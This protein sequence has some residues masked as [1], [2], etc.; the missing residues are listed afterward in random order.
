[1]DIEE[2]KRVLQSFADEPAD[3]DI[4]RGKV[5]AQ[6][7][8]DIIDI[9]L[10]FAK[11]PEQQLLVT[12]NEQ[13]SPARIWLL[14]RVA[15]LPQLADR[16]LASNRSTNDPTASS[17]FVV[18][19]GTLSPD[20]SAAEETFKDT[21]VPNAV[22][23][24]LDTASQPI[25]GAT[26]VLYVTSDAGE[27]K[28]TIINR[29]AQIQAQ[30]FKEKKAS[31]LIVP[32]PLGGRAFLTFDDAVIAALV[33]RF[34]FNYFYFDAFLELVRMGAI[35]P[36]FDGYEEMLVEGSKN[37]AVSAL[38]SLIQSLGSSGTIFIAA[39]KAFFEYLSFRTQAKLLD[40]IGDRSAAFSRLGICRWTREQFCEYGR[41][42]KAESPE[43]MY[44]AV[45]ARLGTGH[46]I[47]TRAVLVRRLFDVAS[48][49][50]QR[51][52]LV[53][54]LGSAPHDY[55]YTFVDA[56][57]KREAS[58][59]WLSRVSG[60]I[61]QPLLAGYE[62][63]EL[64]S[65]VAQEMWQ[66]SATSLR[67]DVI[68]VLVELFAEGHSKPPGVVRQ[69]KERIKQHSLLAAS[70]GNA[71]AFD[72]EDFQNF[73]LGEAFGRLLTQANRADLQTFISVNLLPKAT[74]EQ[75]IQHLLRTGADIKRALK[76]ILEIN[77][78]EPAFSFCKENC[79]TLAVRLSE[80]LHD[81]ADTPTLEGMF[82][83]AD[84]LVGRCLHHVRFNKC[85]FLPTSTA[86]TQFEE[87]AFTQCEFERIE[88][89][90]VAKTLANCSF[91]NCRVDS[92]VAGNGDEYSF[93]PSE[94]AQLL[95]K[96][97]ASID[98]MNADEAAGIEV[99]DER[100]NIVE[101]F[102]RIFLRNTHVDEEVIR[103][104]LGSSA[105]SKFFDEIL[106][107]LLGNGTLEEVP[108]KGRG[109]QRRYKLGMQ[110]SEVSDALEQADSSF[111]EFINLLN[112]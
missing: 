49:Q 46:P 4:R 48:E 64:L 27:G 35:V 22:Q 34:R 18:P 102:L 97:G 38:G 41:L 91:I 88:I 62:H 37:E 52:E 19:S 32:V 84:M 89:D 105:A 9:T 60:E 2:F 85:H 90:I 43:Q 28:T 12:E 69:I 56:I 58:E 70:G 111:D 63:H 55:F 104:R 44:D 13:T 101:R 96:A 57:V 14:N 66:S 87:I 92:V 23:V 65:Y 74:V 81:P 86:R 110:L 108:W 100:L 24:L 106:P 67:H 17:S 3:V 98:V 78:A 42:R 36:A 80:C 103:L 59:K 16:I 7:H 47:L 77:S 6:I 45:S 79:G 21:L 61:R 83:S 25:P 76:V 26:S 73:Y 75:S 95:V 33:N 51:A 112:P 1:M 53:E 107:P 54:L 50:D 8:D 71:L 5:V 68:D 72:H 30:A 82:F 40:A 11:T 10:S 99:R 15:R 39:R 109:V 20:L 94:I 31:S 29:A 93:D